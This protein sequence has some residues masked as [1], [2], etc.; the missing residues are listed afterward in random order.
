MNIDEILDVIDEM[1]DK[2]WSVPLSGG[3]CVVDVEKMR[4]LIDDVRLNMPMEIK[5]AKAIVA[6]RHDI[7]ESARSEAAE[8]IRRGEERARV[9]VSEQEV[10]KQAQAKA[11][12]LLTS[13]Q[14][15]SREIRRATS[16]FAD[17]VLRSTEEVLIQNVNEVKQTRQ[18][19]KNQRMNNQQEK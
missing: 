18:A 14:V 11:N 8:I 10:V 19:I 3:R 16:E 5:Q 9:L 4:D 1:L 15:K 12:E 17:R 6:D 13:A 2:A 7:L